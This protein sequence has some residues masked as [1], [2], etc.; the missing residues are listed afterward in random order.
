M[1]KNVKNVSEGKGNV[2]K[3]NGGTEKDV[4]GNEKNKLLGTY[5]HKY[6]NIHVCLSVCPHSI[7][8]PT[9]D[10]CSLIANCH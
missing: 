10:S 3:E 7:R 5:L 8:H 6:F 4:K 1:N 9:S 2:K